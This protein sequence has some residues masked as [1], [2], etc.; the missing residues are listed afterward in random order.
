MDVAVHFPAP[1]KGLLDA[2]VKNIIF[3]SLA[4]FIVLLHYCGLFSV[5]SSR[6]LCAFYHLDVYFSVPF[7]FC[8]AQGLV[9]AFSLQ[10][11]H[12]R[13]SV[14]RQASPP[15]SVPVFAWR[16]IVP[17]VLCL[18]SQGKSTTESR[19]LLLNKVCF[20]IIVLT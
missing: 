7:L 5:L 8:V 9:L 6:L 10:L 16:R 1:H 3:P 18:S 15:L 20:H 2:H 4:L 19:E 14:G 11:V 13:A 17:S 12:L